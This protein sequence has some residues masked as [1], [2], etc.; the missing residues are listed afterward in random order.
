[1]KAGIPAEEEGTMDRLRSAVVVIAAVVGF[2]GLFL[3]GEAESSTEGPLGSP[4]RV[5]AARSGSD[6]PRGC[7]VAEPE[8]PGAFCAIDAGAPYA[9]GL[10]SG[11]ATR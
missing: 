4:Q 9:R 7:S 3:L 2:L 1:M 5:A 10:R 11:G 8:R 6:A